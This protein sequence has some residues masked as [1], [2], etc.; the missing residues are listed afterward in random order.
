MQTKR[1]RAQAELAPGNQA[2]DQASIVVPVAEISIPH[3]GG[4]KWHC[5][6]D[7]SDIVL[8]QSASHSIDRIDSCGTNRNYFRNQRIVIWRHGVAG[9]NVRVDANAATTWRIIKIDPARRWLKVISGIF[10]IDTALDRVQPRFC[11]RDMP[12][13]RLAR[14]D[15][16]LLLD[17]VASINLLSNGMLHLNACVH[18]HE[19]KVSVLIDQKL[20][21]SSI[22]V[23]D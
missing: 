16:D 11:V 15:A 9:I 12:R 8:V 4:M 14:G 3:H 7:S 19:V 1:S 6:F 20:N 13:K 22:L 21:R 5:G 23:A 17:Q 2:V 10:G 18:F